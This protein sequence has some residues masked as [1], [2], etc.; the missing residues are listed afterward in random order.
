MEAA[1][2]QAS[3]P[4][5]FAS[6]RNDD[7]RAAPASHRLGS[8][9][10]GGL[11]GRI[12]HHHSRRMPRLPSPAG[13]SPLEAPGTISPLSFKGGSRRTAPSGAELEWSVPDWESSRDSCADR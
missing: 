7:L 13:S 10:S 2:R 9:L 5:S 11:S 12:H 3:Y 8:L 4:D 1:D 6:S